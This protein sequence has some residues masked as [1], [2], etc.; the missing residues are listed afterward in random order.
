MLYNRTICFIW[1]SYLIKAGKKILS[2]DGTFLGKIPST[3]LS[4][5]PTYTHRLGRVP[6]LGS[7]SAP[8]FLYY[9]ST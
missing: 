1:Q 8:S 9:Y 5:A 2:E 6:S 3:C 4:L 7:H